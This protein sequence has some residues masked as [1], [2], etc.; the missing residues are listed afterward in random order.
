MLGFVIFSDLLLS[1]FGGKIIIIRINERERFAR[2]WQSET[3]LKP[4]WGAPG[5]LSG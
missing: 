5:W 3:R 4:A 1:G 2:W